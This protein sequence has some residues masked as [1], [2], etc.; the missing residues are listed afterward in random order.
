MSQWV[1]RRCRRRRLLVAADGN[2]AQV[3]G[4]ERILDERRHTAAARRRQFRLN[5]RR[6]TA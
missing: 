4:V 3:R 2:R 5:E 1:C 6:L